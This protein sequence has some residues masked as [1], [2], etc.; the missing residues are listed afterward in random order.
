MDKAAITPNSE[1]LAATDVLSASVK[2]DL[3]L[4]MRSGLAKPKLDATVVLQGMIEPPPTSGSL[5]RQLGELLTTFAS[6]LSPVD[7]ACFLAWLGTSEEDAAKD[8][9]QAAAEIGGVSET[10]FSKTWAPRILDTVSQLVVEEYTKREKAAF[11]RDSFGDDEQAVSII[12]KL[13]DALCRIL[14]LAN[15]T[16]RFGFE[17]DLRLNVETGTISTQYKCRRL[18]P[19][20]TVTTVYICRTEAALHHALNDPSVIGYEVCHSPTRSWSAV[21]SQMSVEVRINGEPVKQEGEPEVTKDFIKFTFSGFELAPTP[22]QSIDVSTAYWTDPNLKRYSIQIRDYFIVAGMRLKFTLVTNST[23]VQ[24]D[25]KEY[26]TGFSDTHL[27]VLPEL[28]LRS[29]ASING[30]PREV[31]QEVTCR[32]NT[33]IFPRSGVEF[34]WDGPNHARPNPAPDC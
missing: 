23:S 22:L 9:R 7:K 13:P 10:T 33:L 12:G 8:R 29:R 31:S 18:L 28:Q 15:R 25:A 26:I 2:S 17:Y 1:S 27:A 30:E 21:T 16:M 6:E 32:G 3:K 5:G 11:L 34:Y 24:L 14:A 20:D 19:A 4:V